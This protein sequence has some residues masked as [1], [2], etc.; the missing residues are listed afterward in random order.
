MIIFLKKIYYLTKIVF[1]LKVDLKELIDI[2]LIAKNNFKVDEFLKIDFDKIFINFFSA[3]FLLKF[4]FKNIQNIW[5]NLETQKESLLKD[6]KEKKEKK[7]EKKDEKDEKEDK[8]DEKEEKEEIIENEKE[9]EEDYE[10][11]EF[12]DKKEYY[13]DREKK[14]IIN[15]IDKMI[16][17]VKFVN[18]V[19]NSKID[20]CVDL[21]R[22]LEFIKKSIEDERLNKNFKKIKENII[23]EFQNSRELGTELLKNTKFD[24]FSIIFLFLKYKSGFNLDVNAVGLTNLVNEIISQPKKPE[25]E[26][27]ELLEKPEEEEK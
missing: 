20:F 4:N 24:K 7:E 26:E 8:K 1:D 23:H 21:N 10:L 27:K 25:E 11:I 19:K 9:K 12:E 3:I 16:V 15:L 22:I 5:L 18:F 17:I 14:R 2:S 6:L 13:K